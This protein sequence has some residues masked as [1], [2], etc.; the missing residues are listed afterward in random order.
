MLATGIV[1]LDSLVGSIVRREQGRRAPPCPA[2]AAGER[3]TGSVERIV[4]VAD[5]VER[6]DV[7]IRGANRI[8][9]PVTIVLD[10]PS[11][12]FSKPVL[13]FT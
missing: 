8:I 13:L 1:K 7:Q 11:V 2:V 10:D 6:I 4:D 12:R 5:S 9:S 3:R